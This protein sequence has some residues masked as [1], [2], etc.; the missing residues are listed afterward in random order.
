MDLLA[1][2]IALKKIIFRLEP[3]R[4]DGEQNNLLDRLYDQMLIYQEKT[5]LAPEAP[6]LQTVPPPSPRPS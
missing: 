4:D 2:A 6:A 1:H 5:S 3:P